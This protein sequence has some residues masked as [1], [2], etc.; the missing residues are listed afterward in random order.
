[1]VTLSVKICRYAQINSQL[2][3]KQ[4]AFIFSLRRTAY[5]DSLNEKY[6]N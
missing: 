6:F 5:I 4:P 1:M 3:Y 2:L